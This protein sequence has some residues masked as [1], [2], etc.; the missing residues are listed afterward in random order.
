M[1][2]K[3]LEG[4]ILRFHNNEKWSIGT[5]ANHLRVHHSVVRRVLRDGV[6]E[7][8]PQLLRPSIADPFLPFIREKL[9]IYPDLTASSLFRMCKE[10]GYQGAADHF[11]AVVRGVRPRRIPEAF[12]RLATLP[13]EEGQ[14]D[15]AHFGKLKVGAVE[16]QLTAFILVLSYSRMVYLSFHLTQETGVFL[17]A[18]EQAFLALGGV[19]RVLLYDNLKSAVLERVGEH[20]RMNDRMIAFAAHHRFEPRPVGVRKGNEKGKVERH[21]RYARTSFFAGMTFTS[22]ADLNT[23]AREWCMTVAA[24]RRHQENTTLTVG[25]AWEAERERL[26]PLPP[27]AFPVQTPLAVRIGKT[28]YARI[29]GNDY[30]VPPAHVQSEVTAFLTEGEILI[31]TGGQEICRH[32]RSWGRGERVENP[33]HLTELW[34][35]KRRAGA[36]SATERLQALAP[37]SREFLEQMHKEGNNIGG[38]VTSLSNCLEQYGPQTVQKAL[39]LVL[40]SSRVTI[41][42]VRQQLGRLSVEAGRSAH[43]TH[44]GQGDPR[45]RGQQVQ[46]QSLAA[47][48]KLGR[49]TQ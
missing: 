19:P 45:L 23:K 31:C 46:P 7:H 10:R 8:V 26:L 34:D 22:L 3:D 27:D 13:G 36:A 48:D 15:W 32:P 14:V 38:I 39:Q 42:H 16:R 49:E 17:N 41:A 29:G 37:A 35:R 33:E 44:V 11:R 24:A 25:Q 5:I 18:H 43:I 30:T 6:A 12:A 1:I 9:A 4:K 28:P 47:W 2:T 40:V 21:V 20:I